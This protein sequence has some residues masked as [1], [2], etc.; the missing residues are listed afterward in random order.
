MKRTSL[1]LLTVSSFIAPHLKSQSI[2]WTQVT[3]QAP[4][5]RRSFGFAYDSLRSEAVLFGGAD[6]AWNSLSSTWL[7]NGTWIQAMPAVSPTA[8]HS[9]AMAFDHLRQRAVIFGGFVN[10]SGGNLGDTW[11]WDGANWNQQVTTI[12]PLARHAHAMAFDGATGKVILFGGYDGNSNGGI[13]MADTW[14][15]DGLTWTQLSPATT[16]PA[17]HSHAMSFDTLR[18]RLVMFGGYSQANL[19]HLG[20]TWEW[21]GSDWSLAQAANAPGPRRAHA[22][23]FDPVR[24][25]TVLFGGY[26]GQDLGDN[27]S[28]DGTLWTL[29]PTTA[30]PSARHGA[31]MVYCSQ[32]QA[33]VLFGGRFRNGTILGDTWTTSSTHASAQ[34]Y[35]AGCG[36]PALT[37]T[38]DPTSGRPVVGQVATARISNAP[39]LI[40]GVAMGWSNTLAFPVSLPFDLGG[41]GMPGC[42]LL[43]SNDVFGL[44]AVPVSATGLDFSFPIPIQASLVG[45]RVYLQAFAVAPG[46]NA[47]QVVTSNGIEWILGDS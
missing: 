31:G 24:G 18:Q 27:W 19:S 46:A 26:D 1:V 45:S 29:L 14:T 23:A 3:G 5:A 42:D 8:R 6:G 22:M 38:P 16:P 13:A 40:A 36:S 21:D 20:D 47:A 28:W 12:Q 41:I 7:W 10:L 34:I 15:W 30:A 9:H 2:T 32:Q 11:E 44:G 4:S 35:G 43:H 37:F 33:T 39:T 17:R 25:G